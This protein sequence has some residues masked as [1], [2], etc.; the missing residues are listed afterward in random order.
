MWENAF[1]SSINPKASRPEVGPGPWLQ[2]A[3]FAHATPICYVGNFW[4]ENLGPP[5]QILD[6]ALESDPH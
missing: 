3:H 4:P 6:P 1:L 2:S 5:D